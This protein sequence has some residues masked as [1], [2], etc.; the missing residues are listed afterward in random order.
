VLGSLRDSE[1]RGLLLTR[2]T[3]PWSL[4]AVAAV[5]A[6]AAFHLWI[7]PSNPPGFIRDEASISY[8][9]YTISQTL[10]DQDGGL[11]PLF[12]V[13]FHDYKSPVFV[14]LLAAVFRVVGPHAEVARGLAAVCVLAAVLAIGLIALRRSRSAAAALAALVLAGATPWLFELGRVAYETSLL[15][16]AVCLVLLPLEPCARLEDWSARRAIPVGLALGAL[17]YVYAAGRLLALVFAAALIVFAGRG[18]WRWLLTAWA[19]FGATLVPLAFYWHNHPG[20]L[21]AR[22]EA[23]T[24]IGDDMSLLEIVNTASSNYLRDFNLWHWV[25]TGDPKPYVHAYG[26]GSLLGVV[27]VL[28][29]VGSALALVRGDLFWRYVLVALLL[30]PIPAALTKDR[31]YA[32]RLVPVAVLLLVLSIPALA[33]LARAARTRWAAR[34]VVALLALATV[35][36]FADFVSVY[37]NAGSGRTRLFE[38]L[39]PEILKDYGLSGGRT[40]Y[41]DHDDRYAQTHALWFA[42]ERGVPRSH[43]AILADGEVPAVGSR[44]FGRLE[45]CDFVC[46]ELTRTDEYW[47]AEAKGPRPGS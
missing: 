20:A 3:R 10:R 7:D 28:A 5:L 1:R 14:Y 12:F 2:L 19:T 34:A 4:V 31:F 41:I 45:A 23:T 43:V 9:A 11:L 37:R 6:V 33:A 47:I 13:S 46:R 21:T 44:V 27:A 38:A 25:T 39:V 29:I 36:Q 18:R 8:N 17:T 40:F 35:V 42:A 24:F 22:Y 26:T 16:I 30:A 15:P 32:L